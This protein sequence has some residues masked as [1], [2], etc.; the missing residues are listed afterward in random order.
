VAAPKR[1]VAIY[2]PASSVFFGGAGL[3]ANE[4]GQLVAGAEGV[5]QGGGA[6]L[7]MS[8]LARGLAAESVETAIIVWP[9]ARRLETDVPEPDLVERPAYAGA[10]PRAKVREA[11]YIWRAMREAD[12]RAYVFRGGGPQLTVGQAFCRLHR[13][14]LIFSA[15]SDLDFDFGRPDRTRANLMAYRAALRGSD[16]IVVQRSEQGDLAREAGLS[17]IELIPSF[18]E[19]AEVSAADPEAFLWIGRLVDYKRP[20]DFVRLAEALPRARFRMVWFATNE[21][22]PELI[23]EVRAAGE[24]LANLDL[25]GHLPR[26]E[27][28]DLISRSTAVVSTSRAEGMPNTFLEAWSRGVPVVSLDFDPDGRIASSGLGLVA[29]SQQE[30]GEAASRIWGDASVRAEMGRRARDHVSEVHSPAA[31]SREWARV[32]KDTLSA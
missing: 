3:L 28:L 13:R 17:P 7:Q 23:A 11:R 27:L 25:A 9:V 22:R 2:S 14:K 29:H 10:G 19:P 8:M 20:M 24:R 6:E 31:V 32:L 15:A 12:A 4:E 18:A 26:G 21:T 5:A 1:D 30:L 16:L